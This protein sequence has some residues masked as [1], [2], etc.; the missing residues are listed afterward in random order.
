MRLLSAAIIIGL[1]LGMLAG[2]GV[3]LRSFDELVSLL[4][5]AGETASQTPLAKQGA[6]VVNVAMAAPAAR[7]PAAQGAAVPLH[8]GL[9]RGPSRGAPTDSDAF[10]PAAGSR[11]TARV[12][13]QIPPPA[14][15]RDEGWSMLLAA[16]LVIVF[17][18]Y[19]RL[20]R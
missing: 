4:R 20:A 19:R 15:D 11:T 10:D 5:N 14:S 1:A 6:R 17:I 8:A 16:L 12:P 3:E 13:V 7:E 9:L 18:G 2:R